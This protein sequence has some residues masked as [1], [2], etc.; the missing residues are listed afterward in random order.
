MMPRMPLVRHS[1]RGLGFKLGVIHFGK[2]SLRGSKEK[3]S[4][5]F[6]CGLQ[7]LVRKECERVSN[8]F[9]MQLQQKTVSRLPAS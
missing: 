1:V 6:S 4:E 2:K 9:H 8:A 3:E 5:C 7:K